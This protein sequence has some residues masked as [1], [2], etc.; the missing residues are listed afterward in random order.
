MASKSDSRGTVDIAER[1]LEGYEL[2]PY[3][4]RVQFW[5]SKLPGFSVVIG[6]SRRSFVVQR[7][8]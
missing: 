3:V 5:D 2:A 6:R 4:A 7:L 8:A 1:W